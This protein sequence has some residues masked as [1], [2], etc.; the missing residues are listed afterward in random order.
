MARGRFISRTLGR[1]KKYNRLRDHFVKLVYIHTLTAADEQGRIEADPIA[2]FG[3]HFVVDPEASLSRIEAAL[4]ELHAVG[5]ISLYDVDDKRYA[6]FADFHEHNDIRRDKDGNPTREGR[7]RIPPPSEGTYVARPAGGLPEIA[8][9]APADPAQSPQSNDV[10]AMESLRSDEDCAET[11]QSLRGDCAETAYKVEVEVEGE[12][13]EEHMSSSDD[14]SSENVVSTSTARRSQPNIDDELLRIWNDNCGE[15]AKARVV[16]REAAK[17]VR[18]LRKRHGDE[19]FLE[20]FEAGISA[21]RDD[22]WWLGSKAKDVKRQGRPYG[23]VNYLRHVEDL[24]DRAEDGASLNAKRQDFS[25]VTLGETW[26]SDIG[27]VGILEIGKN[28]TGRTRAKVRVLRPIG[29]G[30]EVGDLVD[31]DRLQLR[32]R[33]T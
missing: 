14:E 12:V 26:Y 3:D 18:A 30:H 28:G 7:T 2:I 1:S 17:H 16:S 13:E 10:V 25:D 29:G 32:T 20:M 22:E 11:A 33:R 31:V 6:V 15:L 23:L 21:V 19:A 24:H 8:G 27:V 9:R 4:Q 5:L